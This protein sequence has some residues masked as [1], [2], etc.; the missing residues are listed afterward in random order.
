MARAFKVIKE[1]EIMVNVITALHLRGEAFAD[2]C[3]E[4]NLVSGYYGYSLSVHFSYTLYTQDII[5]T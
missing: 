3:I 2:P 4:L 1:K 5:F